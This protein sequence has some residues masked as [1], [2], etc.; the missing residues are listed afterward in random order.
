MVAQLFKTCTRLYQLAESAAGPR[1]DVESAETLLPS[2]PDFTSGF[3]PGSLS[4]R[5]PVSPAVGSGPDMSLGDYQMI[6][7]ELDVDAS[8][9]QM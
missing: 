9:R 2:Q 4:F 3:D 8:W 7:A 6:L 5:E 1:L